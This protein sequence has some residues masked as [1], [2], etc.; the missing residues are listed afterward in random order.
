MMPMLLSVYIPL[1]RVVHVLTEPQ[2]NHINSLAR[3]V[4]S[5]R[6]AYLNV[7]P[8]HAPLSRGSPRTIDLGSPDQSWSTIKYLT[9]AERDQID[10][11]ARVILS[12]CSERVK[13]L[14][15]VEK[16]RCYNILCDVPALYTLLGR[17]SGNSR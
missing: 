2:L 6:K 16:R 1:P 7:D 13:E 9:D 5:I 4:S 8:R 12:R 11:Q 17:T 3:M 10:L 15:A 14:E